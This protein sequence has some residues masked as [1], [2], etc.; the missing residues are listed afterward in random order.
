[1]KSNF[2]AYL[3]RYPPVACRVLARTMGRHPVAISDTQ[4]AILSGLHS[5]VIHILSRSTSWDGIDIAT[6]RA[7]MQGCN[8]DP[9]N[10]RQM[11]RANQ[12]V[13]NKRLLTKLSYARRSGTWPI[14]SELLSI[15]NKS[16]R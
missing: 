11:R 4:I 2:W 16:L 3:R 13:G 5:G 7:F 12:Y 1:M 14:Y 8:M 9:C 15:W 10:F 6:A